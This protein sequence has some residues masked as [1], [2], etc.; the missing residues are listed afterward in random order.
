M[1]KPCAH[2]QTEMKEELH[3]YSI[4]MGTR[5]SIIAIIHCND[6]GE[7]MRC[8]K[9]VGNVFGLFSND[10]KII[11]MAHCAHNRKKM[12]SAERDQIDRM[13]TESATNVVHYNKYITFVAECERCGITIMPG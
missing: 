1:E 9:I 8:E 2:R 5:T 11:D 4:D 6:C 12:C 3:R 13:N 7:N 10:W